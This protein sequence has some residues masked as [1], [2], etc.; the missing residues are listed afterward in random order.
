[1]APS[2]VLHTAPADID[3]NPRPNDAEDYVF[4]GPASPA[5]IE[6]D[7]AKLLDHQL[8]LYGEK[9]AVVSRW[10]G[11]TLTYASLHG[12][13]R[14]VAQSLVRRGVV[15][16]DHVVV[17]AGNSIEYVQLFFAVAGIGAIFSIIN[18]TFT[19][20]EVINAVNFLN[21]KAIF[22]AN[23]IGYRRNGP[24]LDQ[25]V[26]QS[27]VALSKP[28]ICCL[29]K[30]EK[31]PE[32]VLSWA[33][34]NS[35]HE[36]GLGE[37][38]WGQINP[39]ETL[40]IQFT[41]G[42]T[43]PRKAAMLTHRNLLNNGNLVGDRLHFS[44]QDVLCCCPPLFH[45]FGLVCGILAAISHGS[46]IILPSDVFNA[47]ASLRAIDEE[48][49]TAIHAVPTMFQALLDYPHAHTYTSQL[50]LRTGIIAGSSLSETLLQRL[51]SELRL[52][53][54]AY[55]FGMTELS[56]VNFMTDPSEISLL[57]DRSSTGTLLP[58][59]LAKVVD[60][61]LRALPPGARGEL[62]VSGYLVFQGYHNNPEKTKEALVIDSQGRR[63][64]RTGDIVTL[65]SA[66]A[67][68]VVGRAKDMIK[69]G[70][71]N[72]APSD[73]EQALELHPDI[74][75]AAVV[76][77][78]DTRWGETIGAFIKRA[79]HA[80]PSQKILA[81]EVRLWLRTRLAPHKIPE[82]IFWVGEGEG[83]P[84]QLPVNASG[85]ILKTEL[86][87]IGSELVSSANRGS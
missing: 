24:L 52:S 21:P 75:T 45:C 38:Y 30:P 11:I 8:E 4:G 14:G 9:T 67:C 83:V 60:D 37:N 12:T 76:G 84:D 19:V 47:E 16:G 77:I 41:S 51:Q 40:C 1:M 80:R 73:V 3:H 50:R 26:S 81:K 54:L 56:A 82:H 46:S 32:N 28:L 31:L 79:A 70:G 62:L 27:S 78:P 64:L 2:R 43:G 20:E 25:L 72:V 66:G 59:T 36:V 87:H 17:L 42:T 69:R 18:P 39:Q 55:A 57:V 61:G 34:F 44:S 74:A 6:F 63:W 58:H 22:I 65:S 53:G 13:S 23:R 7:T 10:Q 49:C 33:E 48:G 68:T 5:L 86:G 35:N 85:K 29:G 15:R 71:E